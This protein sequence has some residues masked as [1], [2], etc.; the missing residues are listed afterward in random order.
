MS[1]QSYDFSDPRQSK[2]VHQE[3]DKIS[4]EHTANMRA[5][6]ITLERPEVSA[7]IEQLEKLESLLVITSI[8]S[9]KILLS[10]ERAECYEK[11]KKTTNILLN[12]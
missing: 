5:F 10:I 3:V 4:K 9:Q 6:K 11:L 7:P 8:T 2:I 1:I 12:H